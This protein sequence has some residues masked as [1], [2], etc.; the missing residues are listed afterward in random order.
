MEPE[1]KKH[2][3]AGAGAGVATS[4]VTCP[5]DVVKTRMQSN[6]A[7]PSLTNNIL[8]N[9]L[10]LGNSKD[11]GRL[12][13]LTSLRAIWRQ[14]GL[15]GLYRGLSPT[16]LGYL[17][18]FGIYFP[19]YHQFK[20][21]YTSALFPKDSTKSS[22]LVHVIAAMSAGACSSIVTNPLWLV[23]TRLMTQ[24]HSTPYYYKNTI[25][26]LWS[27]AKTEG[28][29]KGWYRGLT[30]SVLGLLHVA[31]QFPLYE[32]AK[33]N[34]RLFNAE[35]EKPLKKPLDQVHLY[36]WQVF[37]SSV[38]SKLVAALA[39]YPHEVLRTRFQT[40]NTSLSSKYLNIPH[41][42]QL[43]FKEEGVKGFYRGLGTT[44]LRVIPATAV[45]FVTFEWLLEHISVK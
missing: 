3:L 16:L 37:V 21:I 2:I 7:F 39:T 44:L 25:H 24:S 5:L 41:A 42:I 40:S 31:V 30:P 18:T 29:I 27:I 15:K 14:E 23:R 4:L 6:L 9:S 45:T 43:I 17:P 33:R 34:F 22:S 19:A 12:N 38:S 11:F 10:Q 28:M 20:H 35:F 26:A 36:T 32:M 13:T 8:T 1:I